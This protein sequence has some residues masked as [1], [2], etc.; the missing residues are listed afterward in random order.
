MLLRPSLALALMAASASHAQR[1]DHQPLPGLQFPPV[2][3]QLDGSGDVL[4]DVWEM[5]EVAGWS[6]V[7]IRRAGSRVFD[8]YWT[9]ANGERVR[10]ELEMWSRER[11]VI[12]ARRHPGG[13]Y[14]RYDGLVAPDGIHVTGRYTCTWERTPM[15]WRAQIV[16]IADAQPTILRGKRGGSQD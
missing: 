5:E 1:V 13:Q 2:P 3:P 6:G 9:N 10:A 12:V 14:C 8:A 15:P 11:E 7:W 4:G 16:R